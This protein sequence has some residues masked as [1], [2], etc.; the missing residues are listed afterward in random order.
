MPM[1]QIGRQQQ[2]L[3]PYLLFLYARR[4]SRTCW[5]FCATIDGRLLNFDVTLPLLKWNIVYVVPLMMLLV[6]QDSLI[7]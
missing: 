7:F 1:T 2:L 4:D 5:K 6:T 3:V